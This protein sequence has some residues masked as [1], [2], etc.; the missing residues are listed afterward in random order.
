MIAAIG[1][2]ARTIGAVADHHQA[3]RHDFRDFFEDADHI[4]HPLDGPE[5][6]HV[7]HQLVRRCAEH[8]AKRAAMPLEAIGI[9]EVRNHFDGLLRGEVARG[10]EFQPL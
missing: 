4:H 7:T 6:R 10:L 9:D 5:V 8:V 1:F 3:A 2:G